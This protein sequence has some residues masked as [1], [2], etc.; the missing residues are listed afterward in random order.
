MLNR[1]SRFEGA[2]W[3]KYLLENSIDVILGGAGSIGSWLGLFLS[4]LS[5]N[6]HVIVYDND[7]YQ[8]EN[9]A[10]QFT[11]DNYLGENKAKS[12][13]G[14]VK[15][16]TG[17]LCTAFKLSYE[18]TSLRDRYMFSAFDNMTSRK[19]MYDNWKAFMEENETGGIFIDARLNAEHYQVFC[20]DWEKPDDVALYEEYLYDEGE[21][22]ET[23]CSFKYTRH[24]AS[25]C[26]STM[27]L[28]FTNYICNVSTN[29][30]SYT[31]PFKY[32]FFGAL[33]NAETIL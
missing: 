24:V 7:T 17:R 27:C 11:T 21:V 33:A 14:L 16:F 25:M 8:V 26:A 1:Y 9:L 3:Y 15:Q 18:K 28:F 6:I 30:S 31:V 20:I 23:S 13:I 29:S 32:E 19:I 12:L 10:G 4:S 22:E 2:L 5:E